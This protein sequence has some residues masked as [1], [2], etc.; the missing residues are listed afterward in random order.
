MPAIDYNLGFYQ[1]AK[2]YY[3]P[4]WHQQSTLFAPDEQ[5]RDGRASPTRPRRSSR[6]SAGECR[7][8]PRRGRGHPAEALQRSR[9]RRRDHPHLAAEIL[10]AMRAGWDEVVAEETA[11]PNFAKVWN[12]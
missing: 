11:S 7:L 9:P 4:G 8:R 10:D 5:G 3:F 1:V 12:R 6:R 2:H